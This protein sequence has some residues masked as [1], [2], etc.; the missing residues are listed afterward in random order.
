MRKT[1]LTIEDTYEIVAASIFNDYDRKVL[2]RLYQPIIGFEAAILY[3]NLWTELEGDQTITKFE[4]KHERL[5]EMM[6]CSIKTIE[7]SLR[8]LEAIGL[9]QTYFLENAGQNRYIYILKS[10]K[11]PK[12]FYEADVLD[13]LLKQAIGSFEY[14][15]TRQYF[16]NSF[17]LDKE[18]EEITS[19]FNAVF[20]LANIE[21]SMDGKRRRQDKVMDHSSA[22]PVLN[23]DFE[24]LQEKLNDYQIS[25]KKLSK[26]E[27]D[28]LVNIA[29]AYDLSLV[30]LRT[31]ILNSLLKGTNKIDVKKLRISAKRFSHSPKINVE[32][33]LEQDYAVET[34]DKG[35]D[36]KIEMYHDLSSLDF[37]RYLNKDQPVLD[38]DAFLVADL[39]KDTPLSDAVINVILDYSN[40][41]NNHR[42]PKAYVQKIA[43]SLVRAN[44]LDSAYQAM[45][46][47][48]QDVTAYQKARKT[49]A[50]KKQQPDQQPAVSAAD[51]E[52]VL[53]EIKEIQEKV[54][55]DGK[56][57]V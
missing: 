4:K 34:G 21:A 7:E 8:K 10:P 13:V 23:F 47:L 30:D 17:R 31:L 6:Q 50:N 53:Q 56:T 32:P 42:L 2:V 55:K 18:Y 38:V 9:M 3:F 54:K 40:Q 48:N 24:G 5:V 35:M 43:G 33:N 44:I 22:D 27:K 52:K 57:R 49:T 41:Q 46:Y 36:S 11:T 29:Y 25:L 1:P 16:T 39:K 19:T 14:E 37:L 20:S 28:V 26:E 15:R 12:C 45:V 51:V